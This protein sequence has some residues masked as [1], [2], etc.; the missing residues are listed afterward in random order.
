MQGADPDWRYQELKLR[1]QQSQE[2]TLPMRT[3]LMDR[4]ESGVPLGQ[5]VG[6]QGADAFQITWKPSLSVPIGGRNVTL[7]LTPEQVKTIAEHMDATKAPMSELSQAFIAEWTRVLGDPAMHK[8]FKGR[9]ITECF[10]ELVPEV[11]AAV[12]SK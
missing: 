4:L 11:V 1:Q 12:M 9:V 7:N 6:M 2:A 3:A 10:A 5:G 8:R